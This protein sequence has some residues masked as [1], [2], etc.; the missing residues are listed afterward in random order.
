MFLGGKFV[1]TAGR[2]LI[3]VFPESHVPSMVEDQLD[4]LIDEAQN[5]AAVVEEI[6][7]SFTEP[8]Q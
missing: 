8:E 7:R 2:G 3:H 6:W 4:W 1:R 5:G